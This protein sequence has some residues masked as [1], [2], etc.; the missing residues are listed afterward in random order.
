[1]E[2]F[3]SPTHDSKASTKTFLQILRRSWIWK[4]DLTQ[5]QVQNNQTWKE[6]PIKTKLVV[7]LRIWITL[8]GSN[9]NQTP[10]K[11]NFFHLFLAQET[12]FT[13]YKSHRPTFS[14]LWHRQTHFLVRRSLRKATTFNQ[15]SAQYSVQIKWKPSIC[16]NSITNPSLGKLILQVWK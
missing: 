2:E 8:N 4:T 12:C 13:I 10:R 9:W 16:S 6:W 1:M 15:I 3:R 7:L 14:C 11:T 5:H